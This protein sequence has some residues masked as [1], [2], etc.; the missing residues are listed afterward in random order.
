[1]IKI[2]DKLTLGLRMRGR[3]WAQDYSILIEQ[4]LVRKGLTLELKIIE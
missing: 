3:I 1:M 2:Q 4:G